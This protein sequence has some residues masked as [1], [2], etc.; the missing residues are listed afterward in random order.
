MNWLDTNEEKPN[1]DGF[2]KFQMV[3]TPT[4]NMV[5]ENGVTAE[6]TVTL[7]LIYKERA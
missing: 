6:Y 1:I 7:Q 5:A 2:Q 4:L 3:Q